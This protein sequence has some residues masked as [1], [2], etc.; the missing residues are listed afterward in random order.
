LNLTILFLS[1]QNDCDLSMNC[2][3][4]HCYCQ[5]GKWRHITARN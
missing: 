3:V 4:T 5:I 2:F 1:D